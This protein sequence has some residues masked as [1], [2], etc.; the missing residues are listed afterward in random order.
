ML[1]SV[2]ASMPVVVSALEKLEE[3]KVASDCDEVASEVAAASR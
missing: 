2:S 1:S 3:D